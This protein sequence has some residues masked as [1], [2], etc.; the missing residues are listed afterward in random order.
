M[1]LETLVAD[2]LRAAH[3]VG[4][5]NAGSYFTAHESALY[6]KAH[7]DALLQVADDFKMAINR[8]PPKIRNK[9]L[10]P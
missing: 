4:K 6:L 10:M 1:N 9:E 8:M 2:I 5:Q 3:V 7:N